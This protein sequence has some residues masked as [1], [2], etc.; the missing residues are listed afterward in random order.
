M[1]SKGEAHNELIQKLSSLDTKTTIG[2]D[3]K[4]VGE[5]L[6]Q[7]L[8]YGRKDDG[9]LQPLEC[10]GD[11]L[12]VDV[13]E[14]AASGRITTSS[15]LSSVQICGYDTVTSR[16]KTI[17]VNSDGVITTNHDS[18]RSS[19]NS[20]VS[21]ATIGAN[22]QIG[23]DIDIGTKKS[24]VIVGSATG[25]HSIKILHSTNGT[26]FYLYGEVTPV[27]FNSNYHYNIKIEDG[28]QH[29]RIMNSNQSNTFTINYITL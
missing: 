23:S 21:S 28:L 25:N 12:L 18:N 1:V 10:L 5:G 6:Q 22:L 27:S 4:G 19:D 24:I 9:T 8:I 13:V 20:L 15:A 3:V 29:Y 17:D 14:L 11:R 26:D 7:T 2:Q 16:F